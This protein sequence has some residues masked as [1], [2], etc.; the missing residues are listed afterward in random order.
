MLNP[1][2]VPVAVKELH[3]TRTLSKGRRSLFNGRLIQIGD[4]PNY[5]D[6]E[7]EECLSACI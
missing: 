4:H 3:R 6:K 1:F 5:L 2:A 7:K